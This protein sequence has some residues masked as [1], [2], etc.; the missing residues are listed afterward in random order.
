MSDGIATRTVDQ[1]WA[2]ARHVRRA[3]EALGHSQAQAADAMGVS[4]DAVQ[5][6]EQGRRTP[7]GLY[8]EAARRYVAR[9]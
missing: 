1:P 9:A 8:A 4:V 3:R 5:D 6:W 2:L 7:R